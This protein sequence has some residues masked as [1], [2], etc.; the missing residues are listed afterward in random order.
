MHVL[1]E[2]VPCTTGNYVDI[3][4][5]FSPD[6]NT[7]DPWLFS[8]YYLIPLGTLQPMK[9]HGRDFVLTADILAVGRLDYCIPEIHL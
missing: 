7:V 4:V 9:P 5:G 2:T 8:V 1:F 3:T 6:V